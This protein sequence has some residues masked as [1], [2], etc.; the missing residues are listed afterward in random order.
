MKPL[1]DR[2]FVGPEVFGHGFADDRDLSRIFAIVVGESMPLEDGDAQRVEIIRRDGI[3]Q[4]QRAA[5]AGCFILAFGENG[6]GEASP[7]WK[8]SGDRSGLHSGSG[9]GALDD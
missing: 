4:G 5:V 1:A 3:N 2:A 7:K 6:A 9:A 8:V